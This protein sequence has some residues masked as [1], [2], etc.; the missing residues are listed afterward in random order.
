M[1]AAGISTARIVTMVM[2]GGV[3]LMVAIVLLGEGV[4][5]T[6]QQRAERLRGAAIAG[7]TEMRGG[8]GF[9][10]RDGSR[11]IH[12]GEIL[13]GETLR[14][15]EVYRFEGR[16]LVSAVRAARAQ[17]DGAQWQVHDVAATRIDGGEL[18]TE[19]IEQAQW[20]RLVRPELF[21]LLAVS[22][23]HLSI[24][25]L[26]AYVDYLLANNLEARRF[27]L[28]FWKKIVT[29]VSTLVMLLL[30]LPVIF[31]S[32]RTVS[33]GQRIFV[34]SLIGVGYYLLFELSSHIGIVYGVAVPVAALFPAAV[35]ALVGINGLRRV[36]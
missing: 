25:R 20:Q 26:R 29:P 22:P 24:W 36:M 10:V 14:D 6:A 31:G 32:V 15:I 2:T 1:R 11:Y 21:R 19:R 23:E 8:G 16:R 9:W 13:P 33:A 30:A 17:F 35:F 12:V 34:G 28:A 5:P 18:T 3:I 7:Q 27:Q 4:A